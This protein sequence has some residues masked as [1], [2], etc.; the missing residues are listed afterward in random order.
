MK[1][2]VKTIENKD[3]GEITLDKDVFGVE[4][5]QDII[6]SMIGYQLNKRRA[7]THKTKD[8][9]EVSGTGKKPHSQKGTGQA[10]A[11]QKRRPQTVGGGVSHGPVVRSHATEMPK[12]IRKLALCIALSSKA[13]EGKLIILD[14]AKSKDHKTKP[15]AKALEKMGV[16]SALIVGGKEIDANFARATANLPRVDVLPSQDAN[17]YD[18]MRRDTL[19]LT[20]DAV[21]DL[22]EKLKG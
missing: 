19:I 13:K 18:I 7:G 17:V 10:R 6:H 16:S 9:S 2:A 4:I 3:A 21:N 12:K 15:M 1:L 5:R 22:T 14:D 20:K 8:V 11:G